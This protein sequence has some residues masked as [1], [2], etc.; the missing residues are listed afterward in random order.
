MGMTLREGIEQLLK[1]RPSVSRR[2]RRRVDAALRVLEEV[3]GPLDFLHATGECEL[4]QKVLVPG[5]K[6]TWIVIGQWGDGSLDIVREEGSFV[7]DSMVGWRPD[8]SI[9]EYRAE[10]RQTPD[11]P[12]EEKDAQRRSFVPMHRSKT[13][14]E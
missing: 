12:P 10:L 3:L 11:D 5:D 6:G 14:Q 4:A 13:T 9:A 1:E 8:Q 2:D 7:A